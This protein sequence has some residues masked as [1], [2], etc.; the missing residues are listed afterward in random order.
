MRREGGDPPGCAEKEIFLEGARVKG[1]RG[2]EV[3]E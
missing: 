3:G 2:L 1:E